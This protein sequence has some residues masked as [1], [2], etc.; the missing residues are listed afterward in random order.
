MEDCSRRFFVRFLLVMSTI[1]CVSSPRPTTYSTLEREL[2]DADSTRNDALR[3]GDTAALARLYADDF[4]MITSAGQ[5]RTKAD[6][7]RDIG[8]GTV[9]HQGPSERILKMTVEGDMAVVQSESGAGTL[10][11]AGRPDTRMRR[12]TRVYVHRGGRWQLLA[13]HISIVADSTTRGH[14]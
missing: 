12:Y 2:R 6:Q 14:E 11:T 1:G 9:A 13:T 7:L 3:S 10:V 4:V 5:L 8:A